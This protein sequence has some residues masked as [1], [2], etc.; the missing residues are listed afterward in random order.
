M[1]DGSAEPKLQNALEKASGTIQD[2]DAMERQFLG[3]GAEREAKLKT[4]A[5]NLKNQTLNND[6]L[7]LLKKL[8]NVTGKNIIKDLEGYANFTELLPEKVKTGKFP[9]ASGVKRK[10]I[11]GNLAKAAAAAGITGGIIEG[12]KILTG[13]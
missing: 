1:A 9:T 4:L 10:A 11:G 2:I 3:S 13:R 5:S 6:D 7:E 12:G 8:Q